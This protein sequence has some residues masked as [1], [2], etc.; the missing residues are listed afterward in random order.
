M[1]ARKYII[2]GNPDPILLDFLQENVRRVM[3]EDAKEVLE[4]RE[5]KTG[6]LER[7][8]MYIRE[9]SGSRE[10]A[11]SKTKMELSSQSGTKGGL[12]ETLTKAILPFCAYL[13]RVLQDTEAYAQ[14]LKRE[15]LKGEARWRVINWCLQLGQIV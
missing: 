7:M 9:L 4:S 5:K 13:L 10:K 8:Y 14:A 1:L 12:K 6:S 15:T 11:A 2:K 3:E